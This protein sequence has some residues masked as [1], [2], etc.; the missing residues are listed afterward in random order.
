MASEKARRASMRLAAR[1]GVRSM[2]WQMAVAMVVRCS[3]SNAEA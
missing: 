1:S 3:N 2:N